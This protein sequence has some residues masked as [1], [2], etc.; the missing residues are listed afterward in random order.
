MLQARPEGPVALYDD[1]G[2]GLDPSINPNDTYVVT[3]ASVQSSMTLSST[4]PMLDP[5]TGNSTNSFTYTSPV[6]SFQLT[7]GYSIAR[8]P[9]AV[10]DY[11]QDPTLQLGGS[12]LVRTRTIGSI[13]SDYNAF[14]VS[15]YPAEYET[16]EGRDSLGTVVLTSSLL[17]DGLVGG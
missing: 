3:S 5:N 8:T 4:T 9:V 2:T 10:A 1:P 15:L 6:E 11:S 17:T 13:S 16:K 7:A 12:E 14:G